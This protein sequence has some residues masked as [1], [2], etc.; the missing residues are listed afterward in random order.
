MNRIA[1]WDNAKLILITLV[2]I[3]HFYEN[4]LGSSNLVNALFFSV[5]SFHMP[6]FFLISGLFAKRTVNER[7]VE[8][9]TPYLLIYLFMKFLG[10]VVPCIVQGDGY[11][12]IDFFRESGVSW[13]ILALFFMYIITFYTK[14]YKPLYVLSVSILISMLAGYTNGDTNVF[15][16]LRIVIFYPF[17]YAGYVIS[18]EDLEKWLEHK[19]LKIVSAIV[20]VGYFVLSYIGIDKL[21]WLRFLLTGRSYDLLKHGALYGGVLRLGTYVVSFGLV[22]L[23]LCVVPKRKFFFSAWGSR[24]L[25]VYVFHYVFI[26]VYL[27]S[28]LYQYVFHHFP[29]TWELCVSLLG[30][31]LTLFCCIKPFDALCRRMLSNRWK[32]REEIPEENKG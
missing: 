4:Y 20:L 10:W 27:H 18:L 9:V 15:C 16:W 29:H 28:A 26:N 3:C 7:R 11:V 23:F 17:F 13:F 19:A 21:F 12:S 25:G 24:S 14:K 32:F 5:Y 30:I 2:V 31:L 1:K 8:K 22:F 6:A